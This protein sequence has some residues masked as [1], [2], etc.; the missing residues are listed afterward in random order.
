M[1]TILDT[2][3][4]YARKTFLAEQLPQTFS[5]REIE[6]AADLED[7]LVAVGLQSM[8]KSGEIIEGLR[9]YFANIRIPRINSMYN[10]LNILLREVRDR[11]SVHRYVPVK[12]RIIPK[13]DP[14]IFS[15]QIRREALSYLDRL[16]ERHTS[17][18]LSRML[19]RAEDEGMPD[20]HTLYL[21]LFI[22]GRYAIENFE[23]M[24]YEGGLEFELGER[25]KVGNFTGTDILITRR[26]NNE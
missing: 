19:E 7:V 2:Q 11:E 5:L 20:L 18:P 13:I 1:L 25:F 26:S 15:D 9:P 12:K 4:S 22:Q 6:E 14:R 21:C 10:T 3:I 16:L 17:I 23:V 24:Y 8:T